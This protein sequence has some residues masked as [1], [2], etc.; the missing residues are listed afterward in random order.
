MWQMLWDTK[1]SRGAMELMVQG[2]CFKRHRQLLQ[3]AAAVALSDIDDCFNGRQRLL[4][5]AAMAAN[6]SGDGC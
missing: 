1:S 4:T 2:G 5:A 3:W 6:S